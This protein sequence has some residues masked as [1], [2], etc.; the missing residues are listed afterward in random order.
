MVKLLDFPLND[1][2]VDGLDCLWQ[3]LDLYD[4]CDKKLGGLILEKE[5]RI[6]IL[7]YILK[8]Q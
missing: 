2:P 7:L 6:Q 3:G 5:Q 1:S 8:I 4:L